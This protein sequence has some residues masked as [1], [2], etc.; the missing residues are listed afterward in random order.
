MRKLGKRRLT[1][2]LHDPLPALPA[3]ARRLADRARGRRPQAQLPLRRVRRGHRRADAAPASRRTRRRL[4]GPRDDGEQPRGHFRRS[5]GAR[6]VSGINLGGVWAIYR[7]ELSRTVR[8][9]WQSVATPV[10]T[11][12]LY[13]VVFGSAIGSRMR[14]VGGRQLRRLHRSR[15]DDALASDPEHLQRLD[16]HLLPQIHRHDLRDPLGADVVDRGGRGLCR[17][18]RRR[19]RSSSASSSF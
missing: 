8:T 16:R 6:G 3:R 7:Y 19:S 2:A 17:A 11:T 9:I 12:A 10:I 13:F 1:L 4:Q 14:E 18:P 15:P 5:G